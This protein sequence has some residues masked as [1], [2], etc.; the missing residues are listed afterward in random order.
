MDLH[1]IE[2]WG[3]CSTSYSPRNIIDNLRST[4][5]A[6]MNSC[7]VFLNEFV[8]IYKYPTLPSF[9]FCFTV[10]KGV[11]HEHAFGKNY[12]LTKGVI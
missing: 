5:I 10:T 4:G 12:N 1:F 11:T 6:L 8:Q 3:V 7:P 9:S 2:A